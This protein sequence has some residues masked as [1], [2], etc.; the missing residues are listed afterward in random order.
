M[1]F[2]TSDDACVYLVRDDLAV[3]QTVDFFP[4]VVD[5]PYQFGQIAA[6]NALSDIYAMGGEP[7]LAL[8]LLCFPTCLPLEAV[9]D[10]LAGGADK[11]RE[12]GA[13]IAGGHSVDDNEPKYG[14]SVSAF[15]HPDSIW[16]NAGAREGDALILTKPLGSGITTTAAKAGE[17]PKEEFAASIAVMAT[18]N[19]YARDAAVT[20]GIGACTDITGFGLMGHAAEMAD[21]SGVTIEIFAERPA[22]LPGAAECAKMGIVPG[23]AYRNRDYLAGRCLIDGNV[24][25]HV[26]DILFDPQ[27]SGGLLLALPEEKAAGLLEL[28]AK[29]CPQS[30]IIGRVKKRGQESVRVL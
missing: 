14:L 21:A 16:T 13:I 27:T 19:K 22:L 7:T 15:A 10:I 2:D 30:A 3:I 4:P 18:L 20:V 29:K 8:N 24:P 9:R 6:A 28:L 23:G 11:V 12:A 5:D 26:Q 25:L 17:I 1:G